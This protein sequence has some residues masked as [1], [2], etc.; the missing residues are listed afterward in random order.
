MSC[1]ARLG[2]P[3]AADVVTLRESGPASTLKRPRTTSRSA[4]SGSPPNAQHR[5]QSQADDDTTGNRGGAPKRGRAAAARQQQENE[6]RELEAQRTREKA[7]AAGRRK[8]RADRRRAEGVFLVRACVAGL[9][10]PDGN[11]RGVVADD[12]RIRGSQRTSNVSYRRCHEP[13]GVHDALGRGA[14]HPTIRQERVDQRASLGGGN[15]DDDRSAEDHPAAG[16]TRPTRSQPVHSRP[17]P[18]SRRGQ[19]HA[20]A[21]RRT[22]RVT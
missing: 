21:V 14:C 4:A 9:P 17:R 20:G 7:E 5:E 10:I 6:L 11:E 3:V 13:A 8:G 18:R 19:R 1:S 22:N 12:C 16:P 15:G 2:D